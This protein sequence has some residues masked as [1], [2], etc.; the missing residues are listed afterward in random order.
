MDMSTST[1]PWG[2]VQVQ[3]A[4][5]K[6]EYKYG[7]PKNLPIIVYV[8]YGISYSTIYANEYKKSSS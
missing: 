6:Y 4:M 7:L 8:Q 3:V 1:N 5:L 2:W